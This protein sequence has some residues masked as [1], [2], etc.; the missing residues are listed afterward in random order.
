M[1]TQGSY[2]LIIGREVTPWTLAT[3]SSG[4]PAGMSLSSRTRAQSRRTA[5]NFA[6][7]W[8]W[9]SVAASRKSTSPAAASGVRPALV[10]SRRYAVPAAMT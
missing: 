9:S 3:D 7:V 1:F 10:S 6:M 5:R 8:N 4:E 2:L